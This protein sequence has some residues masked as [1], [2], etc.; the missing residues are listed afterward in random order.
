MRQ[1]TSAY[2]SI[3]QHTHLHKQLEEISAR[4]KLE[5]QVINGSV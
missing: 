2:V 3:R 5:R 1:P 4:S